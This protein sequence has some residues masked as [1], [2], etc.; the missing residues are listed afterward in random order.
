MSY[1]TDIDFRPL[2]GYRY[3]GTDFLSIAII[4][5]M[6][7]IGLMFMLAML[8]APLVVFLLLWAAT[9][10]VFVYVYRK[11]KAIQQKNTAAFISFAQANGF[12]LNQST[13]LA[14]CHGTIFLRGHS[15]RITTQIGGQL[16]DLPFR[17]FNYTYT[18]G[19]GKHRTVY[20]AA[21]MELTLPRKLP[22]MVI[23]SLV[24]MDQGGQSTLPINFDQSQR[25]N[26]EGDFYKYFALYAPDTYG[27][28]AL[29]IIAP[30][31][32]E[33][34]MR[35]AALCDIEIIDDKIY[36]YWPEYPKNQ[37]DY[38]EMFATVGEVLDETARKLKTGNIFSHPSQAS[39]H[40]DPAAT[41]VRLRPGNAGAWIAAVV[42]SY[43]ALN[44]LQG[45][46]N[47]AFVAILQV[48]IMGLIFVPMI[49]NH[50]K[51]ARLR[52]SLQERLKDYEH[53]EKAKA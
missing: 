47:S 46:V 6:L 31:V 34:L 33:T 8:G 50:V 28:S 44:M 42:I 29:S 25:L 23:D 18:V 1:K 11:Q 17:L 27:V 41:G 19:S 7:A 21:V 3:V 15:K 20:D 45:V 10:G 5:A 51:K 16:Q 2:E 40:S 9:G 53:L 49:L 39:I 52:K 22:H 4:S 14:D 43:V 36:F 12:R 30:D 48:A 32:M 35:H 38:Q 37:Q 13:E 24:E 26:L